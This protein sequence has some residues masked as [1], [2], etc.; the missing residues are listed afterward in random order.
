MYDEKFQLHI[1]IQVW[2]TP[3]KN[4]FA[5]AFVVAECEQTLIKHNNHAKW[6]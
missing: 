2:R 1:H 3:K 5:P 6:I 4:Q